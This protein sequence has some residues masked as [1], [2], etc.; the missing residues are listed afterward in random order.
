[1]HAE[2]HA[3]A[4]AMQGS[5]MRML[6]RLHLER[7]FRLGSN[8]LLGASKNSSVTVS[9]EREPPP[10]IKEGSGD[11]EA[12]QAR[13]PLAALQLENREGAGRQGIPSTHREKASQS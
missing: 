11:W 8:L 5:I 10:V 4:P 2:L 13:P 7:E 12:E 9:S 6:T 3:H 1:M